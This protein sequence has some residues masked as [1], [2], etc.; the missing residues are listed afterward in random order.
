[1]DFISNLH[2]DQWTE[3][4]LEKDYGHQEK[5]VCVCSRFVLE[6]WG[7]GYF[8]SD[9]GKSNEPMTVFFI[10]NRKLSFPTFNK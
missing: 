8:S 6:V 9:E 5:C 10:N 3:Q 4:M 1:M 7:F 2:W